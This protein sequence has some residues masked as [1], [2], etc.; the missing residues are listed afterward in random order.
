MG[1]A[2][3]TTC[4]HF[5]ASEQKK[6][7]R[8][9]AAMHNYYERGV[10]HTVW[11][12]LHCIERLTFILLDRVCQA[13]ASHAPTQAWGP[14]HPYSIQ[15]Q[16]L[17]P[18]QYIS[19]SFHCRRRSPRGSRS[20]QWAATRLGRMECP[21]SNKAV[22]LCHSGWEGQDNMPEEECCPPDIGFHSSRSRPHNSLCHTEQQL[23]HSTAK[24]SD[25]ACSAL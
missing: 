25:M 2:Q 23:L 19:C 1:T 5:I 6:V 21:S 17:A 15:E 13:K 24:D 3:S 18:K 22:L 7:R 20:Y 12:G 16:A 14:G 9:I 4:C 10:T 11:R 8:A